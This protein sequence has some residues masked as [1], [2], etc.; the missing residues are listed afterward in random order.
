VD[1]FSGNAGGTMSGARMVTS[2]YHRIMPP[3]NRRL[4]LSP[5]TTDESLRIAALAGSPTSGSQGLRKKADYEDV[6]CAS[7]ARGS[8]SGLD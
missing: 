8:R 3:W 1:A 6:L 2:R 5:R 7:V 4:N